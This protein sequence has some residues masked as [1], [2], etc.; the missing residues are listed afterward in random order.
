MGSWQRGAVLQVP[1]ECMTFSSSNKQS[2]Q[3]EKGLMP[4]Y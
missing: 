2:Y 1:L 3:S 4:L